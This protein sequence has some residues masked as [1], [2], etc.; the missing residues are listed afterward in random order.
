VLYKILTATL[1]LYLKKGTEHRAKKTT[2]KKKERKKK[3]NAL[4][5]SQH[6]FLHTFCR[7]LLS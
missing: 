4:K 1:Q 2:R 5:L 7:I 3:K 6:E